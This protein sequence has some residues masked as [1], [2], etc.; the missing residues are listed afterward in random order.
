MMLFVGC[1]DEPEPNNPSGNDTPALAGFDENGASIAVYSGRYASHEATCNIGHRL[2]L[3]VSRSSNTT[4]DSISPTYSGWIDLFGYGTSG[5]NN[6]AA[7]YQPYSNSTEYNDY[8]PI[9]DASYCLTGEYAHSDWGVHNPISNGGKQAGIW[10]VLTQ[11][12]WLYLISRYYAENETRANK[13]GIATVMG[14]HG[15]VL[16]LD[17][18]DAPE[19]ITFNPGDEFSDDLDVYYSHNV[20]DES[21]WRKME[22]LGAVFLPAAGMRSGSSGIT[23]V[24]GY[25]GGYWNSYSECRGGQVGGF[26]YGAGAGGISTCCTSPSNGFSVRLVKDEE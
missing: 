16:L 4:N 24:V 3:G 9:S 25:Y 2:T 5:W 17:N 22:A 15:L 1:Q 26:S 12:E 10:R 8:L 13:S 21:E 11:D 20:Y 14:V 18:W 19:G 7:A 6:G 23:M